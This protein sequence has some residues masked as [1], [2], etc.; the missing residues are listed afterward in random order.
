MMTTTATLRQ[1][2]LYIDGKHVPSATGETFESINPATGE[3]ICQVA[4]GD[5]A[6][7]NLAAKAARTALESGPWKTMDAVERGRLM[8]KLADLIEKEA[9]D[10]AADFGE[11]IRFA[12][13]GALALP[14]A[15]QTFDCI[16][17][18]T[19]L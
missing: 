17:S 2:D 8:F 18:V 11:R 14:F 4:E 10:L 1:Y 13:G 15:D 16:F 19:M 6:D 9:A 5:A 3:A 12:R 7:I